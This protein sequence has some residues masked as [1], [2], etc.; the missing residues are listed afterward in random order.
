MPEIVEPAASIT[1]VPDQTPPP[2]PLPPAV[3]PPTHHSFTW[4]F[5]LAAIIFAGVSGYLFWQNRSLSHQLALA[6]SPTPAA[7]TLRGDPP[8]A[9]PTAGWQTYINPEFSY[10]FSY[11]STWVEDTSEYTKANGNLEFSI[12]TDKGEYITG[13]VFNRIDSHFTEQAW[14]KV[15]ELQNNKSIL[16]RYITD[17]G[18]G[19][20]GATQDL[21]MFNQILS[22]FK[23][24]DT[25]S[26]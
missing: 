5:V 22:T 19:G 9:D 14:S 17:I 15:I 23:F 1:P 25:N 11:P 26:E 10:S 24:T 16:M 18:E 3:A 7:S 13:T 12:R 2:I 20:V 6:P 8:P 4:L 21:E